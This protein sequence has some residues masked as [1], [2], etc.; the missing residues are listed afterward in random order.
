MN[1]RGFT[2]IELLT[3]MS[4]IGLLASIA[5]PKYQKIRQ[6]ATAAELVSNIRTLPLGAFQYNETSGTWPRTTGLGDRKSVV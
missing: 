5:L 4:I 2:L 3:T 1:R 6:R